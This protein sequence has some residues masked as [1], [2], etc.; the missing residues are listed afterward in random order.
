MNI[1][2]WR[3]AR[4]ISRVSTA[5]PP[6]IWKKYP[7]LVDHVDYIAV[8]LLPYWEGIALKDAVDYVVN[9]FN[10]LKQI[11]PEKPIVIG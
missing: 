4:R 5:E 8:H 3:A 7:E 9:S 10:E 1:W 2:I 11:Y 6:H